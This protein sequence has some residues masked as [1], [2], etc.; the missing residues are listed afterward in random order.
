VTVDELH[1]CDPTL[2]RDPRAIEALAERRITN[3]HWVLIDTWPYGAH[4]VHKAYRGR[5]IGWADVWYRKAG[6]LESYANPITGLQ[7]VVDLNR[8]DLL[9]V[10]DANRLEEPQTMG[11]YVPGRCRASGCAR[12]AAAGDRQA[13]GRLVRAR[14]QSAALAEVV[15]AGR[16]HAAARFCFSIRA[17]I[18]RGRWPTPALDDERASSPIVSSLPQCARLRKRDAGSTSTPLRRLTQRPPV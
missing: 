12:T 17:G 5:R 8:M 13:R 14:R 6:E 4:L 7:F 11:E 15:A 16:L 3:M 18:S 9:E 1:D 2:R 10:E